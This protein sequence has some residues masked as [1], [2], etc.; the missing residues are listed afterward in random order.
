MPTTITWFGH[1]GFHL[2]LNGRHILIDPFLSGNPLATISPDTV[3]AEAILLTHGHGDHLG[4]TISIAKRTDAL[5]IA[6]FE[7][8]TWAHNKGVKNT[9]A[10][11]NGGGYQHDFGHVKFVRADHSS[12]F[13]D[14]SY[15]GLACGIVLTYNGTR[16]YFAGDTALFSDM[17]L[18]G[19]MEIDVAFIPI[20]DNYTMG[21][22]D[23]ILAT[24]LIRPKAVFPIHYNTFPAIEQDAGLWATQ[25]TNETD[26]RAIVI[27]PNSSFM[28]E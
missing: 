5:V 9:H 28:L 25:I 20:G 14:G 4:D 22:E 6:T 15:A 13:P 12:S 16:L 3:P 27:D 18:I 17:K 23:S 8:A 11:N 2:N 26:A 19:D 1:S 24:K 7:I 21:V 10:Q